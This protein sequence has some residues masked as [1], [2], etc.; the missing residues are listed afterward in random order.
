[1]AIVGTTHDQARV[2]GRSQRNADGG[3]TGENGEAGHWLTAGTQI[4]AGAASSQGEPL[5]VLSS[6]S[7]I[8]SIGAVFIW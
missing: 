3:R 1:M 4:A 6:T 2:P 8:G 5:P 7:A